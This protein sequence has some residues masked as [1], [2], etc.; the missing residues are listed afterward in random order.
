M[1]LFCCK[2]WRVN[3]CCKTTQSGFRCKAVQFFIHV[4]GL[5]LW[6]LMPLSTIFQLYH[7]S[8]FYWWRKLEYPE[9]TTDQTLSHNVSITPW[10]ERDS[11][12]QSWPERPLDLC[13][14]PVSQLV[15]DMF[16]IWFWGHCLTF[17]ISFATILTPAINY[18]PP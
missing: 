13:G 7:G 4:H 9:K 6:Y 12:S 14:I 5:G 15:T 3:K 18:T 17:T 2:L 16:H 10:L 1:Y 8:H 11:N